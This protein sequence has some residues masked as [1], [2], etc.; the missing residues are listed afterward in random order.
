VRE[1]FEAVTGLA[2][3]EI[4][5]M[6]EASGLISCN[7]ARGTGGS[8]SVGLRLPYTQVVCRRL[9]DD[10]ELGGVCDPDEIGAVTISGPTVSPGY[11][12]PEQGAGTFHDGVLV[13]GDLGRL[14]REGRLVIGGRSKDQINRSGHNIDPQMIEDALQRHPDVVLAAAVGRPD[15][16]AG[17]LP[18]ATWN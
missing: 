10:G 1:R 13:T 18:V 14:D 6:T 17:E 12:D 16:Y 9:G 2:V 11:R 4:Y 15:A 8:G 3:K 5:G 7:P